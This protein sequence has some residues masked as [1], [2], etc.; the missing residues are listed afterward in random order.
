MTTAEEEF[1]K[2]HQKLRNE[3]NRVNWHFRVLEYFRENGNSY[4][5]EFNQA[6]A[7]WG[8]TI[9]AHLFSTLTRLNNF[10]GRKEKVKH[11][12]MSSFLD[13]VEQNLNIFS[14][15]AFRR[16]LRKEGRYDELAHSF[17]GHITVEK[18]AQDRQRLRDLPISSLKGWRREILSHLD[19]NFVAQN[20]DI[21]KKYPIKMSHLKTIIDTLD[22]MLNEYSL[23]YDFS[24]HSKDLTIEHGIK[25]ILDAIRF[26]LQS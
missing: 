8:L 21:A 3:L 12:H 7:F 13:F 1:E 15:Q 11:L 4:L 24:T 25:Y 14:T 16:R 2:Y 23:A 6:P 18:I 20:V 5:R 17:K 22:K 9:N 19:R 10:F 26:K